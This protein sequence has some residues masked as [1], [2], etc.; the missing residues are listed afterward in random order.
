[1]L[2]L[3]YSPD[4]CGATPVLMSERDRARMEYLEEEVK[5]LRSQLETVLAHAVCAGWE[6]KSLQERLNSKNNRTKKRKVQVNAQ[7]ISSAEAIRILDEQERADAEKR[8]KEEEAQAAKKAKDDQR[9]RQREAGDITFSG[10]LNSKT[11]DDLLDISFALRLTSSDSNTPETKTALITMINTHL[12]NNPDLASDP[13]FTGLFLSRARGRKRNV[14]DEN[15]PPAPIPPPNL[16][17]PGFPHQPLSPNFTND[18]PELE[19]DPPMVFFNELPGPGRYF[20]SIASIP[21]DFTVSGAPYFPRHPYYPPPTPH[22]FD[23]HFPP[24]YYLPPPPP[25]HN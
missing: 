1:M 12:D 16:L 23:P 18:A 14:N 4:L 7:Y 20:Q 17:P 5:R 3:S 13:T 21:P 15:A 8:Q 19:L 9:K 6:I 24:S 2:T 22:T 11:R 10:S 25:P